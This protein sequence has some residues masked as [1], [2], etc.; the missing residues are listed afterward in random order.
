MH[1]YEHRQFVIFDVA[2]IASIDFTQVLE[3]SAETLRVSTDGTRTFVK[4]DGDTPPSCIENLTTKS[5]YYTYTEI[6]EI[7]NGAEWTSSENMP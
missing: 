7:L 1:T 3:T 5:E 2:E 6:V 4:W